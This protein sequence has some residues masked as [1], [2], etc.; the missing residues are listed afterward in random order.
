[1][2]RYDFVC[3]SGH[4]Q[5]DMWTRYGAFPT[6]PECGAM[7]ETL[8]DRGFPNV[9]ADSVP[10]G[11]VVENMGREPETFY[12]KSDHRREAKARGLRIR[13]EYCEAGGVTNKKLTKWW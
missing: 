2:P 13:D 4:I 3:P 1:M 5:R 9:I 10:G 12:S 8:W 7:V 11:F 6:C